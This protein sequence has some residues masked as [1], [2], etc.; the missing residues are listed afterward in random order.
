[1]KSS[2]VAFSGFPEHLLPQPGSELSQQ[3]QSWNQKEFLVARAAFYQDFNKRELLILGACSER[4]SLQM[5]FVQV[6]R[7]GKSCHETAPG[8]SFVCPVLGSALPRFLSNL[9]SVELGVALEQQLWHQPLVLSSS[10]EF[11]P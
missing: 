5:K 1:M 8:W 2:N 6:I 9:P 10:Q 7:A 3:L 4:L 11:S